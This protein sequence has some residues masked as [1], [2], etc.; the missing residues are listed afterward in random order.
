VVSA[1]P[2]AEQDS[3]SA[4][5]HATNQRLGVLDS[6]SLSNLKHCTRSA[7]LA[8]HG[9]PARAIQELAGHQDLGTAQCYMHLSPAALDAAIWLLET[10]TEKSPRGRGEIMEAAGTGGPEG[11]RRVVPPFW[12]GMDAD[13]PRC[14]TVPEKSA[15]DSKDNFRRPISTPRCVVDSVESR[16]CR[17]NL[18]RRSVVRRGGRTLWRVTFRRG[19]FPGVRSAPPRGFDMN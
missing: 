12:G 8:M 13:G 17:R 14:S 19:R 3:R 1:S 11:A 16:S 15:F 10:G 6:Q 4:T 9:A 7:H 18:P 5:R 2:T